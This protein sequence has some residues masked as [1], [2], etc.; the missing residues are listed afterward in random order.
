MPEFTPFDWKDRT[1]AAGSADA[2]KHLATELKKFGVSLGRGGYALYDTHAR[3]TI[4]NFEDE[5]IG[6]IKGGTDAVIVPYQCPAEHCGKQLCVAFEYKV[7]DYE[8]DTP[9]AHL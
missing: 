1:E 2:T 8:E 4:L 3:W 5:K 7:N 6:K 9:Q